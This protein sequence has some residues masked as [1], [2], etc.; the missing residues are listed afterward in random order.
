MKG[1]LLICT[2]SISMA[3]P[4]SGILILTSL[5]SLL[6]HIKAEAEYN[7]IICTF[8]PREACKGHHW[9][10]VVFDLM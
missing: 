1:F 9:V 6:R 5:L 4:D 3:H 8:I 10:R 7:L 2:N